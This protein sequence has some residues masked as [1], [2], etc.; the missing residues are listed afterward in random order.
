MIES[1]VSIYDRVTSFLPSKIFC[2]IEKEVISVITSP[3]YLTSCATSHHTHC[4]PETCVSTGM[5]YQGLGGML[6]A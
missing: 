5:V 2:T 3:S 1:S 6:V 4:H